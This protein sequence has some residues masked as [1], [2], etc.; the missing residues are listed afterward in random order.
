MSETPVHD[1]FGLTY[2]K[3]MVVPRVILEHMPKEWQREF[4]RLMN[5]LNNTFDWQP[6]EMEFYVQA[7]VNGKYGKLPDHLCEYRHPDHQSI[8][9]LKINAHNGMCHICRW[10]I[11]D[12][13]ERKNFIRRG[14]KWVKRHVNKDNT[15]EKFPVHQEI[16][17][18]PLC[19]INFSVEVA[20]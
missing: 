12:D 6:D 10:D 4:V 11:I 14:P 7:R 8:E 17:N 3:W 9:S 13:L 18:C 19:L 5:Q 1:M 15:V 16:W 2:A 20:D